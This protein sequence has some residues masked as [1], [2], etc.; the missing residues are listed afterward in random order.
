[1]LHPAAL[2]TETL[3]ADCDLRRTRRSGPGGQHR[4]KV[5]T[6]V[7]ITHRPTGITAEGSERRSLEQNRLRALFRLR[8][9]LALGVRSPI[10]P[11][12]EP[13]P[14]WQSRCRGGKVVVNLEHEDFPALLAEALDVVTALQMDI[15]AA[16]ARLGSTSSQLVKFLQQEPRAIGLVNAVR[17]RQRKHKLK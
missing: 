5:E 9:N 15:P 13:G 12:H 3:M 11:D 1:M 8:V 7:V 17:E 4:N 14:L 16:A 2:P 10:Q 6:A